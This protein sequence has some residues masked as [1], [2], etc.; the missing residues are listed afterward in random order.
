M[1]SQNEKLSSDISMPI[2][3][4]ETKLLTWHPVIMDIDDPKANPKATNEE[5]PGS[6]QLKFMEEDLEGLDLGELNILGLED[7]CRRKDFDKINPHQI[8]KLEMAL[9]K[10]QQQKK[11]GVQLGSDWDSLKVA[12]ESRKRGRKPN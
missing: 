4:P 10:A 1:Q 6:S 9:S 11:L 8:D 2:P 7:A 12:K 5:N 3:S